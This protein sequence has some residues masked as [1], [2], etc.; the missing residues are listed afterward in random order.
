MRSRQECIRKSAT[1]IVVVT[2]SG[3]DVTAAVV[4]G[5]KCDRLWENPA[6]GIFCENRV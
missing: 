2:L 1:Q 6:Y 5:H 4:V 3:F